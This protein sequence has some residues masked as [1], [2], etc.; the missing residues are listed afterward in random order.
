MFGK[1]AAA[2]IFITRWLTNGVSVAFAS[3]LAVC[4]HDF[5]LNKY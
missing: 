3:G 2:E 1:A 4:S 5:C